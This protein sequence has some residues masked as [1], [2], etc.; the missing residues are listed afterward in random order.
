VRWGRL[1]DSDP[2]M[3]STTSMPN[4]NYAVSFELPVP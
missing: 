1:R 4:Q 3:G 2:F